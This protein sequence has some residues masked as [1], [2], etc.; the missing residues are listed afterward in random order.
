MTIEEVKAKQAEL[1]SVLRA[2]VWKFQR[3]TGLLVDEIQVRH[4]N[5]STVAGPRESLPDVRL[6]LKWPEV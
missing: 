3:E 1:Q 2:E 4:I 6:R 5:T